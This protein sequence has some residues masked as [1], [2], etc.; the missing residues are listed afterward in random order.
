[1]VMVTPYS[2]V[3]GESESEVEAEVQVK[4]NLFSA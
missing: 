4:Q 1:L 3:V 2:P